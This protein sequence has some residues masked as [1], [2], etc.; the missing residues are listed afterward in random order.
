[1]VPLVPRSGIIND[2]LMIMSMYCSK[3]TILLL[4][5]YY[6]A[7]SVTLEEILYSGSLE[8]LLAHRI[9]DGWV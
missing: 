1:M 3:S 4:Y 7:V 5:V 9:R 8:V 2:R 6:L